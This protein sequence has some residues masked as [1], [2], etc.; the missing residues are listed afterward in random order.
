MSS[1]KLV[2]VTGASSGIGRET[3]IKLCEAGY[4]VIISARSEKKL[5]DFHSEMISKGHTTYAIPCDV[6]EYSSVQN[7]YHSAT[8]IGFVHCIINNAGFGKFAKISDTSVEDWDDMINTNLRVA[9]L[10]SK[11]FVDKMIKNNNGKIVFIN[12]VAGKFG[13][14]Y[15]SAYV[16][17]KYG[18]RGLSESLRNELREHNIKVISIHPG[19]IDTSFWNNVN[20]DF[21]KEEMLSS[22]SVAD[23]IF[24]AVDAPDNVTLEEV[25]VRRTKGDF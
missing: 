7:L 6:R 5:D 8:N 11:L 3:S 22:S 24:N 16:T 14:K 2:L 20:V 18:L 10:V 4:D 19:A 1:N 15:S 13:Y 12:S 21:P 25:V 9:F 23:I 17:S